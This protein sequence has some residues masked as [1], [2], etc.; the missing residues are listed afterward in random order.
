MVNSNRV[1]FS[2]KMMPLLYFFYHS[3]VCSTSY[4]RSVGRIQNKECFQLLFWHF[5]LFLIIKFLSFSF[6][7]WWSIKFPQKNINRSETRIRG[8]K[9]SK[10]PYEWQQNMRNTE[11]IENIVRGKRAT[12]NLLLTYKMFTIF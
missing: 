1:C 8:Q 2:N 7:F 12:T 9:L 4:N 5:L 6:F 10:E 11:N 3:E